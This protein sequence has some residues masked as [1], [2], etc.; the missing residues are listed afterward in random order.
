MVLAGVKVTCGFGDVVDV[1]PGL[2][3]GC[4]VSGCPLG[5]TEA[6][7]LLVTSGLSPGFSEASGG[8]VSLGLLPGTFV[9]SGVFVGW[10]VAVLSGG[11]VGAIVGSAVGFAELVGWAVG[12]SPGDLRTIFVVLSL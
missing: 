7:G 1:F 4:E 9:T 2:S 6:S 10:A 12:T 3:D 5:L 8:L 11:I